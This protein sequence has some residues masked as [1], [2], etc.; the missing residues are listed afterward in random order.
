MVPLNIRVDRSLFPKVEE[1]SVEFVE[2]KGLGHPDTIS[3]AIVEEFSKA[4]CR[5]YIENFGRILHHNVD[6]AVLAGGSARP[7][8]GGG[9]LL[10]PIEF[11]VVGRATREYEG[12]RVP[13]EDLYLESARKWVR[14]HIRFLDPEKHMKFDMKVRQG[15]P[16]LIGLFDRSIDNPGANDTSFG[17]GYAPF[18]RLE[19]LVKE[20]EKFLNS[21]KLKERFPQV[22]EDVKVMGVRYNGEITITVAAAFVGRLI[23]DI[24]EYRELKEAVRKEVE[25]HLREMSGL[26]VTVELN[27]ADDLERSDVFITVTGT[28]AEGGDDGQVGRGNRA[29]GLITPMRPM[30][31]EATAGKNPVNHVGKL[32][33]VLAFQAADELVRSY[34]EIE[35]AYIY[36][37]SQ[38]GDPIVE[39]QMVK[40]DLR[41]NSG[42]LVG[43]LKEEVAHFMRDK[44]GELVNSM[45]Q[46]LIRGEMELY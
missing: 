12:K 28:S 6:K 46:K 34:D 15:S 2:R 32:Y 31:L 17:A 14:E 45:R 13:V 25:T 10:E 38:I 27:T 19:S 37:V 1:L 5:Y 35:E 11:T 39:P 21:P 22:G 29:N 33:N 42:E 41:V 8:F 36:I 16:D 9:E 18:T 43:G 4:L 24:H 20:A 40:V 7:K 23:K 44:L 26:D 3:D 30:S